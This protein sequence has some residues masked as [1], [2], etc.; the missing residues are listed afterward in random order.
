MMC[1]KA[2]R[3]VI[4]EISLKNTKLTKNLEVHVELKIR[5]QKIVGV[6]YYH[7]PKLNKIVNLT[8]SCKQLYEVLINTN[9]IKIKKDS[10][11]YPKKIE[12]VFRRRCL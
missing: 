11:N 7:C 3:K 4:K 10:S 8:L 12:Q 9:E 5:Q 6:L 2:S 1:F